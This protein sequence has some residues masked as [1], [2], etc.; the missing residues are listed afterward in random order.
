MIT[1]DQALMSSGP[2]ALPLAALGGVIAGLNPC[3][4]AL[5][6][7]VTAACCTR[8]RTGVTLAVSRA[9][10]FVAGTAVATTCLG[11]IAAVA[12]HAAATLGRGP[13]Y[14]LAFI[15]I[16]AGL[17]LLGGLRIPLPSSARNRQAAT[18][19]AAFG[20]G[21]LLSLVVGSCGT[22]VLASILSYAAYKGSLLFGGLLLFVYGIGNGLPLLLL[23]TGAGTVAARLGGSA[24]AW[25]DRLTGAALI[26]FGFYLL[27]RV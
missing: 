5:Y 20:A 17:H 14:A 7:A 10:A 21:M 12:G 23:G 26:G 1:L 4:L 19:L 6:P 16:V 25:I 15:P 11:L 2:W 9:A 27:I 8:A 22:P 18:A 3:C 24:H 13:R